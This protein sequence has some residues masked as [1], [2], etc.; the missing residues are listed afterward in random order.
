MVNE[1]KALNG[2]QILQAKTVDDMWK[3]QMP[4]FPDADAKQ[5]FK[6]NIQP[7][8]PDL[9]NPVVMY[10][11]VLDTMRPGLI[12]WLNRDDGMPKGWAISGD[13]NSRG[14]SHHCLTNLACSLSD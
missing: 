12:D 14:T 6:R 1:G 3:D 8:R 9:S 7:A 2:A 11:Q 10:V 13:H 5:P 4:A